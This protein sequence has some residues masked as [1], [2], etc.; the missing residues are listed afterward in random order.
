MSKMI[1][2]PMVRLAQTMHQS[3]TDTNIVSKRKLG[4]PSGV[5]KMISKPMVRSTQTV[6]EPRH[7]GVSL[8]ASKMI[9][10]LMIRLAQTVHLS[11]TD[12]NTVSVS[13]QVRFHITHVN[14]EFH[15]V[16]PK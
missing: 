1:S 3:C 16:R 13:K 5:T 11:C 7:L 14:K 8:G 6:H 12:T 2:E 15:R 10:E 9:S 4:F